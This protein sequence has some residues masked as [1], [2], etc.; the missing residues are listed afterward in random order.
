M[1]AQKD[2]DLKAAINSIATQN[3]TIL[4]LLSKVV[5]QG[6]QIFHDAQAKFF[7]PPKNVKLNKCSAA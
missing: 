4:K 5:F 2:G 6:D 7:S 1:Q 3:F